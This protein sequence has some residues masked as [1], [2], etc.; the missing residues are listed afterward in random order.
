MKRREFIRL[1]CAVGVL[2]ATRPRTA[3][4]VEPHKMYRIKAAKEIGLT[5]PE[6]LRARADEV[7]E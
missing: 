7:I 3:W 6:P 1:A 2:A 4:A 5:V